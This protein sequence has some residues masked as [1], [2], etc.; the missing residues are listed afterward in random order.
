MNISKH[1]ISL[2]YAIN[3]FKYSWFWLGIWALFYTSFGGYAVLGL[4]ETV[5]AVTGIVFE[6]PTGAIGDLIGKRWA[7]AFG[8]GV[9][10]VLSSFVN[11]KVQTNAN[12]TKR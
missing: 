1:N 9:L 10:M 8:F 12:Y 6:I 3:V 7:I 2:L 5:M 4:L 11:Y